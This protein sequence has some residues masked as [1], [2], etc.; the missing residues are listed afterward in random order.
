M[1]VGGVDAEDLAAIIVE[2]VSEEGGFIP[3]L[4][5]FP[6]FYL[7]QLRELCDEHG[8]VLIV[9]EI[10]T[11][12][13]RMGTMFAIEHSGVTSDL[14]TM[15]KNLE[16]GLPIA[17]VT[18]RAEIMDSAGPGGLGTTYGGNPVACASALAVLEVFEE[19][20]LLSRANAVGERV[21]GARYRRGT[22]M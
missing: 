13:G 6:D 20:N 2:P 21:M 14:L 18:G 16:G 7:R 19:E 3:F 1:L 15:A 10:Q 17:G 5:P 11:G 9:D 12:F 4:I 22:P 8:V